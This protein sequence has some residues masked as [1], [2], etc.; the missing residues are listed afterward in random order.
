L[1]GDGFG[2]ALAAALPTVVSTSRAAMASDT[3]F[4]FTSFTSFP[5]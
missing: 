4:F 2:G 3:S 1:G 5:T